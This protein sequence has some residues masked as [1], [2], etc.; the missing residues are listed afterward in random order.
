MQHMKRLGFILTLLLSG[1]LAH[2]A[3]RQ[4][5]T[6]YDVNYTAQANEET[7]IV[8]KVNITNLKNDVIVTSYSFT[9]RQF[10][11]FDIVS[12]ANNE[13]VSPKVSTDGDETTVTSIISNY[14]IGEGR[15]NNVVFEYKTKDIA[16]KVGD[17]WNINIPRTQMT[18]TTSLYNVSLFIPESFG[19]K[20]FV[21]PTPAR[22]VTEEGLYKFYFTKENLTESGITASFGKYQTMNYKLKYQIENTT[23]RKGIYEIALPPD[24]KKLQQVK[25][26]GISPKPNKLKLDEDGN[27]IAEFILQPK[28][29]LGVEL[30]GMVKISGRQIN[31][32]Y[33]GKFSDLPSDYVKNYT[34]PQKYW[35]VDAPDIKKLVLELKDDKLTVTQ[36]AKKAYDYV[37]RRLSY[38]FDA[39]KETSIKREGSLAPLL[40]NKK[41]TCMEFT[42]L[43]IAITRAMG[44]PA[45]E[46]NGY[47]IANDDM[48]KPVSVQIKSGDLLH[49]WAE[50]YDPYH[51]WVQ[52]D[53]T[54]GNT[55]GIDYFS[56]LDTNH[57]AFVI[58]GLNSEFPLPAGSYRFDENEKLVEVDYA[59]SGSGTS[60]DPV[61]NI[62]KKIGF[63]IFELI[64]GNRRYEIENTGGTF[65]YGLN[66]KL[67]APFEKSSA[68]L[69][70]N[71]K[72]LQFR[73]YMDS[74]QT[75][76]LN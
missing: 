7:K 62:R 8:Q 5:L 65:I 52:V 9:L 39:L 76:N 44:I 55:T 31:P 34:K 58:K 75:Y 37:V 27:S 26:T 49:A 72:Y 35:D 23:S 14:T 1:G 20:I 67:L 28:Q 51:G 18:E 47:A 17:V 19:P 3:Q 40:E 36:N 68:Y 38:N 74:L 64:K 50:F 54:W 29:K 24:I 57:F 10:S 71:L 46:I 4:F 56:K 2:G 41:W 16:N 13:K 53:P 21:S 30:N 25:Y 11:V 15:Q 48:T 63:N 73:D 61:L 32:T 22:E 59:N 12:T 60:F 43:F 70:K 33:G 66:G 6:E 45:R 69:S 42:D